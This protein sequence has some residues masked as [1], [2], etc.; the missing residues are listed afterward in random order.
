MIKADLS[1]YVVN[2]KLLKESIVLI[3]TREKA[4]E[5]IIDYFDKKGIKYESRKLEYGDYGILL[6]QNV[7][8]GI[9]TNMILDFAVERKGSLEEIS[10]NLTKERV[11]FENELWRGSKKMAILIENGSIDD[12]INNEY[13]TKYN[14]ASFIA[15]LIAFSHR[16]DVKVW[17]TNKSNSGAIIYALLKYKLREELV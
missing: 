9:G 12:I 13:D 17:F 15:T 6:P 1:P 7:E 5:H 14:K 3:D 8:Y 11:R 10:T 4:N 16:Y 2:K